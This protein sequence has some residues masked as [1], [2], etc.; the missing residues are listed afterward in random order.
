MKR[1]FCALAAVL[2]LAMC[3]APAIRAQAAGAAAYSITS[4]EGSAVLH[5]NAVLDAVSYT[6]LNVFFFHR[7]NFW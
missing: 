7:K 2:A 4:F 1:L 3:A 6:H 5:E